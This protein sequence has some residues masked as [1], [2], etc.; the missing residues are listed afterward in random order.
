MSPH[1][2]RH[3][4]TVLFSTSLLYVD[5]ST[6][7]RG[8]FGEKPADQSDLDQLST[9][10]LRSVAVHHQYLEAIASQQLVVGPN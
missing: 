1:L 10:H 9:F 3:D 2:A 8:D 4:A 6:P 7:R 5:H